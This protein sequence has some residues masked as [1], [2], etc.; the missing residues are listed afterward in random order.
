[1]RSGFTTNLAIT[2]NGRLIKQHR[3][4]ADGD[5]EQFHRIQQA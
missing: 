3:L 2:V 5:P 4:G 1:V